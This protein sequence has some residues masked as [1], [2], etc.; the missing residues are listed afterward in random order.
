MPRLYARIDRIETCYK[1]ETNS[2]E[3]TL[4]VRWLRPAPINPYEKNWHEAGL[5]VSCGFFK[6][7]KCNTVVGNHP[8]ISHIVSS[9]QEFRYSD[10]LVELYPRKGEV[11]ALYKD[12]KPFDWCSDPKTRKGCKFH[13]VEI[14][15]RYSAKSGVKVAILVKVAGYETIFQRSGFSF[16]IHARNLFGFSHNIPVRSAGDVRGLFPGLVLDLDPLS[17]PEDVAVDTVAPEFSNDSSNHPNS[18]NQC[19]LVSFWLFTIKKKCLDYMLKRR[20]RL[21]EHPKVKT[22]LRKF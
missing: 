6:L 10:E 19:A 3:N 20:V 1:K 4:Y 14:L 17:I 8:V 2:T 21:M 7:D 16:K 11:W 13:L 18:G 9:F 12:W 5:P 22:H 15:S